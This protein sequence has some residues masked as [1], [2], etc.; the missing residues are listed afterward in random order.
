MQ[1]E[2]W[3]P[4]ISKCQRY[5][6]AATENVSSCSTAVLLIHEYF[7]HVQEVRKN[8]STKVSC[9]PWESGSTSVAQAPADRNIEGSSRNEHLRP[10]Q[11]N[12]PKGREM[13]TTDAS[14][15]VMGNHRDPRVA[16]AAPAMSLV[17]S[18]RKTPWP[19]ASC[20]YTKGT[21]SASPPVAAHGRWRD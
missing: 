18:A 11:K 20:R 14:R 7:G 16:H 21:I 6:P 19:S 10:T 17:T 5:V 2:S 15:A 13:V 3:Q 12:R 8:A 4:Y 9:A 1:I